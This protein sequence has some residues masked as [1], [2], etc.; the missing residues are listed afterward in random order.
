MHETHHKSVKT[1][2][3]QSQNCGQTNQNVMKT[4]TKPNSPQMSFGP[5]FGTTQP[6]ESK[7]STMQKTDCNYV[8]Q[9]H[10]ISRFNVK[11]LLIS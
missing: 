11:S 4:T 5:N 3:F 1:S 9:V 10:E 2:Q 6:R 8:S 7:F